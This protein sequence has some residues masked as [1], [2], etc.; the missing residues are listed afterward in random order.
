MTTM[1][2]DTFK[3][4]VCVVFVVL[5][6]GASWM[7]HRYL[8]QK[9]VIL[10]SGSD[11]KRLEGKS[12]TQDAFYIYGVKNGKTVSFR[13]VD[14]GF[15]FPPYFKL[16]S[17]ELQAEAQRLKDKEVLVKFYGFRNKIFGTYPNVLDIKEYKEGMRTTSLTRGVGFG[18]WLLALVFIFPRYYSV[19]NRVREGGAGQFNFIGRL[20]RRLR[21]KKTQ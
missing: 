2:K 15:G 20:W 6:L 12:A 19:M 14:T 4:T 8:P 9:D 13:N 16:N 11:S 17:S 18:V 5:A 3:Q 10:V 1:L 7:V 21:A